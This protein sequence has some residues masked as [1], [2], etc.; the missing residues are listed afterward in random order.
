MTD[1]LS[2]IDTEQV[3]DY[4]TVSLADQQFGIPI[5]A[6]HDI[7]NEQRMTQVALATG[8]VSGV[9]NIRGRIVTA[10][11]ARRLM[12]LPDRPAGQKSMNVVVH[13]RGE[14]Y[15]L[16]V[17][18]VGEVR[19]MAMSAYERNPSNMDAAWAGLSQ[20]VY[21]LDTG[22]VVILDVERIIGGLLME[23]AA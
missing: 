5:L 12:G 6:V 2:S 17:D 19:G 4:V 8:E 20:G 3:K 16:V 15:A 1:S 9:M 21:R 18:A 13:F 14:P 10:I 23:K 22:L 11:D 7:L